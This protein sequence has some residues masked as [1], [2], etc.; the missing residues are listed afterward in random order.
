MTESALPFTGSPETTCPCCGKDEGTV[1]LL[2]NNHGYRVADMD[3]GDICVAMYLTK[4]HVAYDV[5][6]VAHARRQ[7]DASDQRSPAKAQRH[8]EQT[9]VALQRSICRV[10]EV[11]PDT[12]WLPDL[13][14]SVGLVPA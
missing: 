6:E 13:L 7:L 4:N 12:A 9:E 10:R 8:L 14:A 3:G 1:W 2:Q 5:R 11:W